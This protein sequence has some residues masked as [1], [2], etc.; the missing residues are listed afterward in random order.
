MTDEERQGIVDGEHLRALSI[1]YYVYAGANAFFS[2]FGLLYVFM[3][4]MMGAV[5]QL[6]MQPSQQNQPP[7]EIMAAI[8]GAMGLAIFVL[9]LGLG[10]LKFFVAR[11]L[12]RRRARVFCMIVAAISCIGIPFGTALGVFTLIVLSRDSV[13]RLFDANPPPAADV[14]AESVSAP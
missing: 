11:L 6:P 3:G 4:L 8:F 5:A 12:Q 2:L 9:F 13:R 14:R 10:A 7:P 1:C